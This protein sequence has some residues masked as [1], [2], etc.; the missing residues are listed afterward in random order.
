MS[1]KQSDRISF[2]FNLLTSTPVPSLFPQSRFHTKL[3]RAL[4]MYKL[5]FPTMLT[6]L[7]PFT[8]IVPLNST[9]NMKF[10][11]ILLNISYTYKLSFFQI[12]TKHNFSNESIIRSIWFFEES[13]NV[14]DINWLFIENPVNSVP[15][16]NIVK[17]EC[18]PDIRFMETILRSVVSVSYFTV[19]RYDHV[20]YGCQ[21]WALHYISQ[22]RRHSN[23]SSLFGDTSQGIFIFD[24]PPR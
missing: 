16:S 13:R 17:W 24:L 5:K 15:I 23:L 4:R 9:W 14:V 6:V 7:N 3:P 20:E 12:Y 11:Y 2:I 8:N 18:V 22:D 10:R 21:E 1:D 19:D